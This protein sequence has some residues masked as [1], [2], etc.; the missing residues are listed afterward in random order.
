MELR[1]EPVR[2]NCAANKPPDRRAQQ[3]SRA[4][5]GLLWQ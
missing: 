2:M 1:R 5:G 4:G 3:K